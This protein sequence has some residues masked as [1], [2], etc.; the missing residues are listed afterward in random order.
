MDYRGHRSYPWILS[1]GCT[2]ETFSKDP[3]GAPAVYPAL[4]SA[5]GRG[6]SF[7]LD[8]WE[9]SPDERAWGWG[10]IQIA[11]F[12]CFSARSCCISSCWLWGFF[13]L[14]LILEDFRKFWVWYATVLRSRKAFTSSRGTPVYPFVA[15]YLPGMLPPSGKKV[16]IW[17]HLRSDQGNWCLAWCLMSLQRDGEKNPVVD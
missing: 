7:V 11:Y 13:C 6:C 2:L 17:G 12:K 4:A 15:G 16:R 5:E 9:I 10:S 14:I 1:Q 3:C 8:P